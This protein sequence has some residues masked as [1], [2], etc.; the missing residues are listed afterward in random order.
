M[1]FHSYTKHNAVNSHIL[2]RYEGIITYEYMTSVCDDWYL[3]PLFI[4]TTADMKYILAGESRQIGLW[5]MAGVENDHFLPSGH[6]RLEVDYYGYYLFA[7]FN[8]I[9]KNNTYTLTQNI[10]VEYGS[11]I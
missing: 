7:E 10:G 8:L 4:S 5:L 11:L 6:Y 2:L 1:F 3:V 9:N